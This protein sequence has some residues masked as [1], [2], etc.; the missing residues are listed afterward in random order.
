MSELLQT[1]CLSSLSKVFADEEIQDLACTSGTALANE[2]YSFQVAYRAEQILKDLQVSIESELSEVITVRTVG[3][4]PS[5]LAAYPHHDQHFLRKTPGLYPDPLFELDEDSVIPALPQWRS[6]WITLN[7]NE[8]LT[9]G[10]HSIHVKL[11]TKSG[12]LSVTEHFELTIVPASLPK[13]RLIHTEWF[14][15]DCLSNFYHVDIFSEAHWSLIDKY[16]DTAVRHG[17]NMM[18]TPLFT[19]PLDTAIGGERPT[20]QLIDVTKSGDEYTFGFGRLDRWIQLCEAKRVE[21]LE[22]SHL[23]TQWGAKHAPKIIATEDGVTKRIFGWETDAASSSY[24]TFLAQFLP[25]LVAFIHSRGLEKRCYFH[26]SDEPIKSH[27]ESYGNASKLINTYLEGFP[28]IDALSNYDFYEQGLVKIPIPA[29]N[30]IEPFLEHHVHPLWTYY[31]S[32]Q[33]VNVSNRFF[34][35]P[36]ARNRILG[37]QLY[38]FQ[39]TGFLHWGYNFWN[40]QYSKRPIHPF[41]DTDSS[42]AHPSG[43]AFLVYPGEQGPIESIRLEVLTE[44][45]QDLRALELLEQQ[46]GRER[47]LEVLEEGLAHPLTFSEYPREMEWLLNKREQINRMIESLLS[48]PSVSD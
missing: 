3:L 40:S 22:F 9:P 11:A 28:I 33:G 4:A 34:G 31:C 48:L 35:M 41:Q 37:M 16:M 36:S 47:T 44:A 42:R 27:L 12:S 26:V 1:R 18:L 17:M 6:L 13:Q 24:H 30:H 29:N 2:A 46:I 10:L 45:L 25:E 15:V 43:D 8:S 21:Y 39:L 32:S 14:H 20:V 38:K 5:E 23:F 7:L 19:P